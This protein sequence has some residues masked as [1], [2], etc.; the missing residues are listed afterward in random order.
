MELDVLDALRYLG[1]GDC[2]PER[3]RREAPERLAARERRKR[4]RITAT[5]RRTRGPPKGR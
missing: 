4:G 5:R 2:P 1:A 3:A